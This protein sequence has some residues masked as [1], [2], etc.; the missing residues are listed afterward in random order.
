MKFSFIISVLLLNKDKHSIKFCQYHSDCNLPMICCKNNI[1]NFNY[2]CNDNR[3]VL[4][5][6]VINK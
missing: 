3:Y 6:I 2:C 1:F 5:P 4:K